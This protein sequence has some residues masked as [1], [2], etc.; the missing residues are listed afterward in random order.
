MSVQVRTYTL[1]GAIE[2]ADKPNASR[3]ARFEHKEQLKINGI[4]NLAGI[5]QL[6]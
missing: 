2:F 4:S 6:T 1:P 3:L 5:L